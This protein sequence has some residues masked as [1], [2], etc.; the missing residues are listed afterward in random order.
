MDSNGMLEI[1]KECRLEIGGV[2]KGGGGETKREVI[3][4]LLFLWRLQKPAVDHI[5]TGLRGIMGNSFDTR[6]R[7]S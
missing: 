5:G 6:R 3:G 2:F 4:E 1:V 7:S